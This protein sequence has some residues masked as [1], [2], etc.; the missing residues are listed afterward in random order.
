MYDYDANISEETEIADMNAILKDEEA[1]KLVRQ[2]AH[3]KYCV[4]ILETIL[5]Y[6]VIQD[7]FTEEDVS[8][9]TNALVEK[10]EMKAESACFDY[11]GASCYYSGAVAD[12]TQTETRLATIR[13]RGGNYPSWYVESDISV[14]TYAQSMEML[15]GLL[16]CQLVE[17][18]TNEYNCS[19]YAW[20][21]LDSWNVPYRK[22]VRLASD[23]EFRTDSAY[24]KTTTARA[25][26]VTRWSNGV[27]V[28][29]VYQAS[30]QYDL[31]NDNYKTEPL[32]I[33]KWGGGPLVI[34]PLSQCPYTNWDPVFYK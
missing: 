20:L 13:T 2:D 31:G 7:E 3:E 11:N 5:A 16:E 14:W 34:H 4:D 28:G 18:G 26:A 32:I 27:H 12:L 1:M 15:D 21:S 17:V 33:S 24:I 9:L 30:Y 23:D 29:V 22:S 10:S 25:G 8:I 6:D 19:A